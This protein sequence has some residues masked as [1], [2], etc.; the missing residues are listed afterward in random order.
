MLNKEYFLPISKRILGFYSLD[1]RDSRAT[2]DCG[3]LPVSPTF[4]QLPSQLTERVGKLNR[5]A[6]S[7]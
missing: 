5:Q 7:R 1:S 4:R 3:Q 2:V 6:F